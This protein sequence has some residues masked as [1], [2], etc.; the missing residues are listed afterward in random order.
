MLPLWMD[1]T[2]LGGAYKALNTYEHSQW[3]LLSY[4]VATNSAAVIA[5]L[6]GRKNG[7]V[8]LAIFIAIVLIVPARAVQQLSTY[9]M[10][11][12]HQVCKS[13]EMPQHQATAFNLACIA[14]IWLPWLILERLQPAD[15][16]ADDA[17]EEADE[18]NASAPKEKSSK[19]P[20][21]P[22]SKKKD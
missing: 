3:L 1:S 12:A 6:L 7:A 20:K 15:D 11:V 5:K 4:G 9:T 18:D 13:L 14:M 19:K 10:Q 17:E 16:D 8:A 2:L 21:K 22:A